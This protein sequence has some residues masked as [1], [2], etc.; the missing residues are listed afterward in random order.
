MKQLNKS[1]LLQV[2][3]LKAKLASVTARKGVTL[4]G[5]TSNDLVTIM[6]EEQ[7]T[8]MQKFPQGSFQQIFLAAA[9]G[10]SI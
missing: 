6:A 10:C 9:D 4:D 5:D 8:V 1:S 7:E 3:R 2:E